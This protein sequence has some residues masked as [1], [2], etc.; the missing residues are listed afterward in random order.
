VCRLYIWELVMTWIDC[1]VK[2]KLRILRRQIYWKRPTRLNGW[3]TIFWRGGTRSFVAN[4]HVTSAS[5]ILF[6]QWLFIWGTCIIICII[7]PLIYRKT[8][9]TESAWPKRSCDHRVHL[10]RKHRLP[11]LRIYRDCP[12][13][14]VK[15]AVLLRS[16]NQSSFIRANDTHKSNVSTVSTTLK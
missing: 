15:E 4:E 9:K 16:H 5:Q 13:I 12:W 6:Y 14:Y 11:F 8:S 3:N 10:A 7:I 1:D 2:I